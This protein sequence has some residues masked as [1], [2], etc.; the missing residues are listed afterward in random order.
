VDIAC[1]LQ[2]PS[3]TPGTPQAA[4]RRRRA[5]HPAIR[6]AAIWGPAI[7]R[8]GRWPHQRRGYARAGV[9][10]MPFAVADGASDFLDDLALLP[11]AAARR[12][13]HHQG[14]IDEAVDRQPAR[15]QAGAN[16]A[17]DALALAVKGLVLLANPSRPNRRAGPLEGGARVPRLLPPDRYPPRSPAV[18]AR[19]A[20]DR[21]ATRANR[22]ATAAWPPADAS[23]GAAP[24]SSGIADMSEDGLRAAPR[25]SHHPTAYRLLAGGELGC[26]SD[27]RDRS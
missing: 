1:A 9:A 20:W 12:V 3:P 4:A 27:G 18:A 21:R 23:A 8:A 14:V 26:L 11:P 16:Q 17:A 19:Q 22:R 24:G 6:P 10:G 15:H 5:G 25:R 13:T 2:H 7:R